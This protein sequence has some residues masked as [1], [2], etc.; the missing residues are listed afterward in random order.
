M[1]LCSCKKCLT[2]SDVCYRCE[3]Q[4][5]II[6]V[7]TF[8]SSSWHP[9][10]NLDFVIQ[11][12]RGDGFVCTKLIPAQT[13]EYCGNDKGFVNALQNSGLICK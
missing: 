9:E 6:I 2:C 7:D 8:C 11:S 3:R 1:S 4:G 13:S 12:E 5:A 10:T